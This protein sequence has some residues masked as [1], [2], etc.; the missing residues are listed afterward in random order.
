MQ[1]QNMPMKCM[2]LIDVSNVHTIA[3]FSP[4]GSSTYVESK[5]IRE[6]VGL[7]IFGTPRIQNFNERIPQAPYMFSAKS[8]GKISRLSSLKAR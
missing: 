8:G 7:S 3:I 5:G 1:W 2:N 6:T 4:S